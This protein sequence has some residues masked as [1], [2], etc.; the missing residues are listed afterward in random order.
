MLRSS[1]AFALVVATPAA[2]GAAMTG[3]KLYDAL[4]ATGYHANLNT[5]RATQILPAIVNLS[6]TFGVR[7]VLDVGC[8]HGYAVSWLWRRGFLASGVDVSHIAVEKARRA[9]GEP[10]GRCVPPCFAQ[11]SAAQLPWANRSFDA[12]MSTDVLEHL[13]VG[14]V[15]AALGELTRVASKLMVLKIASRG[16]VLSGAQRKQ[17][18]AHQ[19]RHG[20]GG[21][22]DSG[23]GV[24]GGGE[25]EGRA[26]SQLPTNLH[27]VVRSPRWWTNRIE[28][29]SS[30]RRHSAIGR[31]THRALHPHR[32]LFPPRCTA[33]SVHCACVVGDRAPSA[34]AVALLHD[35][36]RPTGRGVVGQR[37]KPTHAKAGRDWCSDPD[38]ARLGDPRPTP[39]TGPRRRR[40][41]ARVSA[42]V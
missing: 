8:S 35:G 12:V 3:A 41:S 34:A 42:V 29:L 9:R 21:G 11:G 2:A 27:P 32:V 7:S 6:R 20:G 39:W 23:R 14:E 4:Y 22:R 25:G 31:L 37:A 30:F 28:A 17:L 13:E 24:G 5:T 18:T 16:D 15:D 1:L 19:Q 26:S 33:D 36:L 38:V 10:A 40:R